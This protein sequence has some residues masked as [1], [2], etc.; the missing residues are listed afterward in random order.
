MLKISFRELDHTSL[1]GSMGQSLTD[2]WNQF[3]GE[4]IKNDT[5][6]NRLCRSSATIIVAINSSQTISGF[7]CFSRLSSPTLSTECIEIWALFV[8][9]TV[10][11][12]G[13]GTS[14]MRQVEEH[15]IAHSNVRL[16]VSATKAQIPFYQK[17]GY[18]LS[19]AVCMTRNCM[20]RKDSLMKI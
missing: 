7:I 6:A 2:L 15:A 16:F 14:L 20:A 5:F 4:Y 13:I 10:R 8:S 9:P 19:G 18:D 3:N 1:G 11:M 12:L 17:C